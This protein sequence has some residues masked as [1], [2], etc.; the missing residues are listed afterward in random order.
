M[1]VLEVA[2]GLADGHRAAAALNVVNMDGKFD[3]VVIDD[4]T[5]CAVNTTFN[6][7]YVPPTSVLMELWAQCYCL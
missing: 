4:A 6:D 1:W 7:D 2:V 5:L 3:N